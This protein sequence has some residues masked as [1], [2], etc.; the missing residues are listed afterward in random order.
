MGESL[1]ERRRVQDEGLR[2]V[3]CFSLGE[4]VVGFLGFTGYY[5][6][7]IK[8]KIETYKDLE[9]YQRSYKLALE[10]HKLTLNF[11][12]PDKIELGGQMRRASKSISA[13]IAEGFA[14]RKFKKEYLRYLGMAKA[15]VDEMQVHLQFSND[16]KYVSKNEYDDLS[17]EY[18]IL[19]KQLSSLINV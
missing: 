14:R 15:S 2:I 4:R 3:N 7:M 10:I 19:G 12:L 18:V 13:N 5:L 9:V 1:I 11:P 16:L 17:R 8:K 6:Q